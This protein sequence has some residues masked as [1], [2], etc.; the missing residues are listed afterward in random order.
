MDIYESCR[1]ALKEEYA[2]GATQDE[3]ARRAG[4]SQTHINRLL[5]GR[6]SFAT[7]KLETLLKLLPSARL[8]VGSPLRSGIQSVSG[9][10]NIVAGRDASG[11]SIALPS[12]AACAEADAAC[13]EAVEAF[14]AE[15]IMELIGMDVDMAV[16]D[17]ILRMIKD[18]RK[19]Q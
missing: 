18:F 4:I 8:D 15:L 12:A 10:G 3:L 2:K 7:L 11:N 5:N 1:Q 19:R 16:K 13:A 17:Q 6:S 14:R 9:S